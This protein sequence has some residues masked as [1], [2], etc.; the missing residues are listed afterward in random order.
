MTM[1]RTYKDKSIRRIIFLMMLAFAALVSFD[2]PAAS[3]C[4]VKTSGGSVRPDCPDGRKARYDISPKCIENANKAAGSCIDTMPVTNVARIPEDVCYRNEG[5]S[6]KRNHNGMDYAAGMGTAVTAAMDGVIKRFT[7]GTPEPARGVCQ[8]TG[9]GYGNVIYIEHKGCDGTYTTRYG[10]LTNKPVAGLGPGVK[11]KKGQLIGYVGGTGGAC[12]RPH[13]HFELRGPGDALVNPMC[14]Q[15]QGVCN[16]KTP[17]PS[18]GLSKC[19]DATFAAS[20][21][22]PIDAAAGVTAISIAQSNNS[23]TPLKGSNSCAPYEEVRNSQREW[24]CFFCKPFEILFNTASVMA[25]Q[26]FEALAKAVV[27]VVLVAFALWL[28]FVT[29]KFVSTMEI[30]EPRIYIKTLLNQAFRVLVVVILLNSG[31]TTILSNTVDPVFSTGLKVAQLAGKISDTCSL[32]DDNL[33]V[34]GSDQGGLSPEMGT[35][36]LCTIKAIQDQISDILALGRVCWC[37][38]WSSENAVFY[39]FPNLGYLLTSF[40]FYIGGVMLLLI[41]PF[42]LVDCILKLSI[43]VAL[44][45][46]ALGAFAFKITANYLQ[47]I[48]EIFLNAVFSFIFLSMIIYIIASIA[49]DTLSEI[50]TS[51]VGILIKLFW[52]MVEVVKVACVCMLGWAVLG[53][54][55]KFADGFASGISFQNSGDIGGRT[56]SFANEMFLKRPGMA[57]GKPIAKGAKTAGVAAGRVIAE[58]YH[59]VKINSWKNA[60]QDRDNLPGGANTNNPVRSRAY[61]ENGN[62]MKDADGNVMYDTTSAWQKF[63]GKKEYRSFSTDA[64]GNTRMNIVTESR[65][66]KRTETS[67]DAYA[68]VTRKYDRSGTQVSE[69]SKA[70]AAL[71]KYAMRSDG[72]VNRQVINDF[73]QNSMQSEEDKQ[74]TIIQTVMNE[75]MGEAYGGARLGNSFESRQV[76]KST[77][78]EGREVWTVNQVN[79]DGSRSSF[80]LT[81]GANERVMS[82]FRTIGTNGKGV[83]FATDGIVQRKSYIEERTEA[84]GSKVTVTED[85]YSFSKHYSD[86]SG[87]PLYSNGDLADNIPADQIMFSKDA[88]KQFAEQVGRKGNKAYTFKEFK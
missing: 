20:S 18:S 72:T 47:K 46:A 50:I 9:G 49:A 79:M 2:A 22:T 6:R 8:S 62:V 14:D 1:T 16:C 12:G 41:Y 38:A 77:D 76:E 64:N 54:M 59:Q 5:W 17:L 55:K 87:R 29:I 3:S 67:T 39:V 73:M 11:V 7:F 81:F 43:A 33:S 48:W 10:H 40:L 51:D 28:S 83:G 63:R 71:L 35:G 44:L 32:G 25:K 34:V 30:R 80:S 21:S 70:N 24:G 4:T 53:E 84:D 88:M 69:K 85:R 82:E 74:L 66:G 31:L 23:E 60:A 86:I 27:S 36:I 52:W 61:D 19:K 15:I 65:K 42:L 57:I 75:R 68:T 78:E 56:G 37:L 13:L 58:K 45:P 26:A